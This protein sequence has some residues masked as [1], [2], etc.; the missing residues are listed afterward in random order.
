MNPTYYFTMTFADGSKQT[1]RAETVHQALWAVDAD[2]K[3][4]GVVINV[5]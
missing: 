4:H 2:S 5:R 1:V 3:I